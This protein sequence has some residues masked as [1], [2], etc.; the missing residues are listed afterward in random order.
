MPERTAPLYFEKCENSLAFG[1]VANYLYTEKG[2]NNP[3]FWTGIQS[4]NNSR[5]ARKESEMI[6]GTR[7]IVN[8]EGSKKRVA[9]DSVPT[10]LYEVYAWY[11]GTDRRYL[12]MSEHYEDEE[13]AKARLRQVETHRILDLTYWNSSQEDGTPWGDDADI[14]TGVRQVLANRRVG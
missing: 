12:L 14:S 10:G 1:V 7:M 8:E 4:V 2:K 6:D 13:D 5:R 11:Y 9:F 3:T